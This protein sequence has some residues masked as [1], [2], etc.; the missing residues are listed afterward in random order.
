VHRSFV[1]VIGPKGIVL[2]DTRLDSIRATAQEAVGKSVDAIW[3]RTRSMRVGP[4]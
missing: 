4:S 3:S 1:Q 2:H